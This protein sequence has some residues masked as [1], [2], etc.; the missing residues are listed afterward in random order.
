MKEEEELLGC[1]C[2]VDR[3]TGIAVKSC[4][5][6]DKRTR[7]VKCAAALQQLGLWLCAAADDAPGDRPEFRS[8]LTEAGRSAVKASKAMVGDE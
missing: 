4:P 1:G 3:D 6:H 5:G 8:A 7:A 2:L